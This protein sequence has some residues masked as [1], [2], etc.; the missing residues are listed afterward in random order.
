MLNDG[1]A[2]VFVGELDPVA[3][4]LNGAIIDQA[5]QPSLC[6]AAYQIS[7][8][9]PGTGLTQIID[10]TTTIRTAMANAMAANNKSSSLLK[11]YIA[12]IMLTC[13]TILIGLWEAVTKSIL[14]VLGTANQCFGKAG[15]TEFFFNICNF[16]TAG[17]LRKWKRV[18]LYYNDYS[19]PTGLP[20]P[21]EAALA[22]LGNTIDDCTF[23][24]YVRS[25]DNRFP[26][27]RNIAMASKFKFSALELM[28]L[29]KRDALLRS[30]IGTRLR[31]LGSLE[32]Q[33]LTELESLFDQIP[34]PADLVRFMQRDAFN[35]GVVDTFGL[36][37]GF[38]DNFAGQVVTWAGY[39]GLSEDVMRAN[40]RAH[41]S[42]PSPT[43]LYEMY[44]RLRHPAP[45][46]TQTVTLEDIKRALQQQDILPFWQDRLLAV[47]FHPLTRTD[48]FRAY[49]RGWINDETFVNGSYQNGYSDEDAQTLLRFATQERKLALRTSD[50]VREYT[51]GYISVDQLSDLASREG[52]DPSLIPDIQEEA[53]YRRTLADQ[54][55]TV[56]AA[57]GQFRQCRISGDEFR[58][59]LED[60][61]IP[62]QVID[63][64]FN[65]AV[66]KTTCGS[67][68]E[69]QAT[70]ASLVQAG[71]M[72]EDTYRQ[73]MTQLKYDETAIDNYWELIQVKM[74]AA[75]KRAQD[76][77]DKAEAAQAKAQARTEAQQARQAA[78]A[79][80]RVQKA[81]ATQERYRQSRNKLLTDAAVQLGH[82]L[83]DVT[84]PPSGFVNGLFLMLS[85]EYGL[86]QNEAANLVHFG[87]G[88][89][90][91]MTSAA[92]AEWLQKAAPAALL[93]PWTLW[94]SELTPP[95]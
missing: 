54:R 29:S 50:F 77:A 78:A 2:D 16:L 69:M 13:L 11:T 46:I 57:V 52:Y 91:G 33:D 64:W 72:G 48:L 10:P 63:Y 85:S 90:K 56:E 24:T 61:E 37:S 55:R 86:S 35:Q 59:I 41:W 5:D 44:H 28:T 8:L 66:A 68:R 25:G 51:Q 4:S 7:L 70:L 39:Q 19:C 30:D 74:D 31:E 14:S 81:M 95:Q 22:W 79:S 20:S 83:S 88:K 80:A 82:N 47:S 71:E 18:L 34:G 45:G 21:A 60:A 87:A 38:T 32:S 65:Q 17:A 15:T 26:P 42:I 27:Y 93:I 67:R 62:E 89:S 49:E 1:E 92:F 3:V 9:D 75:Q 40:W 58:S 76:K 36:D 84:G 53:E 94:P 43:Q 6:S 23:E 12:A 73:R